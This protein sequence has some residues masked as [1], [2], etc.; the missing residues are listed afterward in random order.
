[1]I[2]QELLTKLGYTVDDK[3][4][5]KY[6]KSVFDLKKLIGG[7]AIGAGFA[8]L[9]KESLNAAMEMEDLQANFEVLL[10][11][12]EQAGVLSESLIDFAN[13][14]PYALSEISDVTKTL[15][16]Y[17][18]GIG[19]TQKYL[20]Q[21]GD[22]ALGSSEKMRSL[23]NVMGFVAASGQLTAQSNLQFIRAGFNPLVTL[24]NMTGK[25]TAEMQDLMS[26]GAIT[27][28]HLAAAMEHA[29]QEGGKFYGGM[30]KGGQTLS[31]AFMQM[32]DAVTNQLGA[33]AAV[34]FPYIKQAFKAIEGID[35]SWLPPMVE[36]VVNQLKS[37]VNWVTQFADVAKI[38]YPALIGVFGVKMLAMMKATAAATLL[39]NIRLAGFRATAIT[40]ELAFRRMGASMKASIVGLLN[41]I[42][43][44]IAGV[45]AMWVAA[46]KIK[47]DLRTKLEQQEDRMWEER[48]LQFG[49]DNDPLMQQNKR[50]L[51][52]AQE[53]LKAI[54]QRRN[55]GEKVS[56]EEIAR[57]TKEKQVAEDWLNNI[58]KARRRV[59]GISEGDALQA[60]LKTA[61]SMTKKTIQSNQKQISFD[62]NINVDVKTPGGRSGLSAGATKDIAEQ[63]V[64]AAFS[65]QLQKLLISAV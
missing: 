40:A 51:A 35:L 64:R 44:A 8:K 14:T 37:A 12:A 39:N 47:K 55:A 16:S 54:E 42:N 15:L 46:N 38:A 60:S 50:T 32:I 61:S 59:L 26:K 28:D 49:G 5:E 10:G 7:V 30:D 65:V 43:L 18:I 29:T 56:K 17:D 45:V 13:K 19:D 25:T 62:T 11:S 1:M 52:Y 21:L 63:A 23:G 31:A 48:Y 20:Q 27:F 36:V 41:P 2:V 9:A 22:I 53:Q 58:E 34:F 4:V 6:K 3:G 57:I 33:V 24:A